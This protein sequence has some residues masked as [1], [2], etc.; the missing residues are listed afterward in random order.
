[1]LR[2]DTPEGN[3]LPSRRSVAT[4]LFFSA[5][6]AGAVAAHAEPVVTPGEGLVEEDVHF[7]GAGGYH[8]PAY[9]A[10]PEGRGRRAAIIVVNEI[11]GI[12]A[13]IKDV[14]RRFAREGYVALAPD[15]F[16]RAGDPAPLTDFAQIRAL[17]ATANHEQVMGDTESAVAWL[18]RQ[19][20]V[21]AAALGIT[22]FCWGGTVVWMAAARLPAIKAG[23]AWYG[24]LVRPQPG[25]WGAEE[26]R[27][28]PYDVGALIRA[29]VL[30]LYAEND[31]G[32][33]LESVESMRASLA[34]AD[35]PT[36]S[37]IVVYPGV[38]H[39]F[40][41]DYRESYNAEAA[42]D[43]WVRCLAWFRANGVG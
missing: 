32:I 30:G 1:M 37:E 7:E 5:Y 12:H 26:E 25:D 15:Y 38:Q 14:C 31:R 9:V 2:L 33:P 3:P 27:P 41:A 17:V 13:Y 19:R 40:H 18:N 35:N 6:A 21:N 36:G 10:R 8:L 43:G 28:W 39:G 23:V 11:F 22:G 34:A 20:F 24:R 42:A 4:S 29:P 16:D